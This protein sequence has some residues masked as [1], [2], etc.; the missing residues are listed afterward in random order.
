VSRA[1]TGMA[2][3]STYDSRVLLHPP[4][5]ARLSIIQLKPLHP[6][7]RKQLLQGY[8]DQ[9]TA[10]LS[11]IVSVDTSSEAWV[12][13]TATAAS[14]SAKIAFFMFINL[15]IYINIT[16][17]MAVAKFGWRRETRTLM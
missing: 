16:T 14:A 15:F 13:D 9:Q 12:Q 6:L 4:R 1:P 7:P 5:L 11:T 2:F 3:D 8:R 17:K 10:V